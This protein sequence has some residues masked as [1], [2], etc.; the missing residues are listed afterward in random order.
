MKTISALI[1]AIGLCFVVL[2]EDASARGFG[3]FRGGFG[4]GFRGGEGRFDDGFRDRSFRAGEYYGA[5]RAWADRG[6]YAGGWG[7]DESDDEP[8]DN[9]D[10]NDNDQ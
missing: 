5:R 3:G 10:N 6:F 8:Y 1:L 9:D 7:V 2:L 4:G